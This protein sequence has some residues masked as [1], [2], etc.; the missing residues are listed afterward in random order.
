MYY[1]QQSKYHNKKTNGFDSKHEADRYME[2]ALLE[3][4][5]MI[6]NLKTQVPFEIIP[7]CGKQRATFYVADFV[8]SIGDRV[9]V[10]DAKGYRTD[11]YKLK[12]KLMKW[13]YNIDIHEV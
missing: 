6:S 3:R 10:E 4:A 5:H 2:L 13:R 7:K 12:K 11:V 9:I 8:Y 1:K